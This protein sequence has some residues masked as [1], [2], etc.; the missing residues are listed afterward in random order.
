MPT[1][2]W[3]PLTPLS[4]QAP[5]KRGLAPPQAWA[6]HSPWLERHGQ[7]EHVRGRKRCAPVLER[8]LSL[9]MRWQH[10]LPQQG[11]AEG[12]WSERG[13]SERILRF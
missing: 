2:S 13:Q 10:S 5:L 6:Q 9:P 8:Q 7:Q 1:T 3:P 11:F 4:S 12:V